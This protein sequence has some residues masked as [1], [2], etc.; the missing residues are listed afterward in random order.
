ME[1]H[2]THRRV[3]VTEQFD[4]MYRQIL[5][6]PSISGGHFAGTFGHLMG[7]YDAG[8]YGYLWSEVY[9]ADMFTRF[10][11]AGLTNPEV[12]GQYRRLV[13]EKGNMAE[14]LDLLQEFLGR[15]P[16]N[17]AFYRKLGI[18]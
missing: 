6:M 9:A 12:G 17:E 18:Q 16:N 7:G 8:Y 14:A 2:T 4:K 3:N 10:Q 1:I 5:G 15:T 13:L 11:A